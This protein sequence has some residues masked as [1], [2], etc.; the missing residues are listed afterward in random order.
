MGLS[1]DL[2]RKDFTMASSYAD[3]DDTYDA[4]TFSKSRD[5]TTFL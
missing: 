5:S 2:S 3:R 1:M 4:D